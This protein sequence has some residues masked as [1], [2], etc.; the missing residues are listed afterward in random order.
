M[1]RRRSE[2]ATGLVAID[3]Q[4]EYAVYLRLE[5]DSKGAGRE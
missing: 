4:A 1:M 5:T 3:M 2:L